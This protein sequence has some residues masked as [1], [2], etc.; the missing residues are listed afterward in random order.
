MKKALVIVFSLTGL[1]S[2]ALIMFIQHF[3]TLVPPEVG[4][5]D[6]S[7]FIM[8]N[9]GDSLTYCDSAWLHKSKTGLFELYTEGDAYYR[10]LVTGKLIRKLLYKQ[11]K[12]FVDQ[13]NRFVP[14]KTYLRF[15][16][17]LVAVFD[18]DIDKR[19][20]P[21]YVREI[22]GLSQY[23]SD[24]FDDI[25]SKYQRILNYQAAHDI[26]H[27]MQNYHLVGCT[28]FAVWDKRAEDSSLLVGRNFDF[29][30]SDEFA[31]D[32]IIS[33]VKPDSGYNYMMITWGGMMGVVS[34]MNDHGLTV[35]V[36]AAK[37]PVPL[38]AACPVSMVAKHILQ[39]AGTIK[40]AMNIAK[41]YEVFVSESFLIG[42]AE[43]HKACIIEKSP[44][45]TVLFQNDSDY[46]ICT[47]HFQS[48]DFDAD[49]LNKKQKEE[50]PTMGRFR[51][52]EQLINR[53]SPLDE[54]NVAAVLRDPYGI[55]DK[56]IGY[57]NELAVNQ[58]IAHHSV[59][60]KPEKL[61]VWVSTKPYQ[62][63]GYVC[64]DLNK[65]FHKKEYFR[66]NKELYEI[67]LSLHPDSV[68]ITE[69]VSK[70]AA[71]KKMR[72]AFIDNLN[73][74]LSLINE[75]SVEKII[76]LNPDFFQPYYLAGEYYYKN[77]NY[78]QAL[79]SYQ[80]ALSK[81]IPYQADKNLLMERISACE[82]KMKK[83]E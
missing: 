67:E 12:T 66:Q 53:Y 70:V 74:H 45:K 30:V 19:I 6:T 83:Y 14:S 22:Y 55:D 27:M 16:K 25:G 63:G 42:S 26:G 3:L 57:T 18:R 76:Q 21:E 80:K 41:R 24:E 78:D 51:R 79:I 15:L 50:T 48:K 34:G 8:K 52:T 38:H 73:N 40:E 31:E 81:P 60:F 4:N 37:S 44:D 62:L 13:I 46:I 82:T 49:R 58:Y 23:A 11:E 61:L 75:R 32:K 33:F 65:I 39:Y 1:L 54:K 5:V 77:K 59:I 64:Y 72:D 7:A 28:S 2:V 47:N 10:G 56:K 35:T 71:Y 43:D 36:N 9:E 17:F 69:Y 68:L 29:Y 20:K